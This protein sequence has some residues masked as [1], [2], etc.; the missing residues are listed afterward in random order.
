MF[1]LFKKKKSREK[2]YNEIFERCITCFDYPADK[3]KES[4]VLIDE[5]FAITN[6]KKEA[7][8]VFWFLPTLI[9]RRFYP[10]VNEADKKNYTVYKC[11]HTSE[12]R[13]YNQNTIFMELTKY[14][15]KTISLIPELIKL[16]ILN[17]SAQLD[18][19]N[20]LMSK[21]SKESDIY[22]MTAFIEH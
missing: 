2:N 13:R 10:R 6:N 5:F 17:Q 20:K 12:K 19:Y 15:D 9:F 14:I 11:D 18:A 8:E 22:L 7:T 16:N 3:P 1:G 4:T 21:G